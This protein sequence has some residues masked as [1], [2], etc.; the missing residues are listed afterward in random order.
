VRVGLI[1]GGGDWAHVRAFHDVDT[2]RAAGGNF[3]ASSSTTSIGELEE[4][5]P[6]AGLIRR[7]ASSLPRLWGILTIRARTWGAAKLA[8][9]V[10]FSRERPA[11]S[12]SQRPRPG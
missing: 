8:L 10:T 6:N 3:G 11:R 2:R 7:K 9:A 4:A 12:R 5:L 1:I